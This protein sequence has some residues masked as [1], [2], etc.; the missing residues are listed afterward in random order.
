LR[1]TVVRTESGQGH[2]VL[3]VRL[4]D[5][6]VV[7]DNL[8]PKI[9]A[10]TLANYEWISMHSTQNPRFWSA[11]GERGHAAGLGL[12]HSQLKSRFAHL[13]RA[14]YLCVPARLIVKGSPQI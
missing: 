14:S 8:S 4:N 12:N 10:W 6:D 11:I 7:L 3:A 1:L 13:N 5:G 2:L 9:Q